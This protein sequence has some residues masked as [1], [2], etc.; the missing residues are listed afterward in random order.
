M[1][2]RF[3][4]ITGSAF[5][6]DFGISQHTSGISKHLKRRFDLRERVCVCKQQTHC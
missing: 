4:Y 3:V 1:I 6:I 2:F 5:S